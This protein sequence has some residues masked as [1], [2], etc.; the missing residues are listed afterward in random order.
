[1]HIALLYASDPR[2]NM[3][4]PR[5]GYYWQIFL[6]EAIWF[7]ALFRLLGGGYSVL[8]ATVMASVADVVPEDKRS[9]SRLNPATENRLMEILLA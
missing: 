7:S 6:P 2:A 5:L 4:N 9:V 1:V 3:F 8:G